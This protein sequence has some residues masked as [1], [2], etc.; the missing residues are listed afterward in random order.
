MAITLPNLRRA[1]ERRASD[2]G[3]GAFIS[4]SGERDRALIPRIQRGV[5]KL[6]KRW[7]QLPPIRIFVDKTSIS[8]GPKLWSKIE[9]GLSRSSW[10]ILLASPEAAASPWVTREVE[11]WLENRRADTILIVLTDGTLRWNDHANDFDADS[12]ALPPP[13]HGQFSEEPVWVAVSWSEGH[14]PNRT[15]IP[16]VERATLDIASVVRGVPKYQLAS[17]AIREHKRTMRWARGAVTALSLLLV[18]ALVFGVLT[19]IQKNRADTEF[20]GAVAARLA[21][22]SRSLLTGNRPPDD[23]RAIGEALASQDLSPETDPGVLLSALTFTPSIR[24]IIVT[25][26][27]M[28]AG[29]DVAPDK[30]DLRKLNPVN[31][32]AFSPDGSRLATAGAQVR[33]WDTETG[34]RTALFDTLLLDTSVVFR[35]DGKRLVTAGSELQRWDDTGA[36]IGPPL[37]G[38]DGF[39]HSVAFSPDGHRLATAGADGTV[40]VWD[41]DGANEIGPPMVGHDGAVKG[42]AFSHDGQRIVSGGADGT[43][44]VW[45]ANSQLPVG[46]PVEIGDDVYAVA[47]HPDDRRVA[48]GGN[49]G[50]RIF[51]PT[52]GSPGDALDGGGMVMLT[53]LTLAF[54][55][56]GHRVIASGMDPAI[57][58]WNVDTRTAIGSATGHTAAVTSV[59]FSPDGNRIASSSHDGTVRIWNSDN[60]RSGGH[61]VTVPGSVDGAPFAKAVALAPDSSRLV[62][63]FTDG[64]LQIVDTDS[65]RPLKP[66]MRGHRGAIDFAAFGPDGHR[67]ASAGVDRTVRIWNADTG[68]AIG[69]P[70]PEHTANIVQLVFSPDG[71]RVLSTSDDNTIRVWDADSGRP[72]G[73]ALLG[74]EV[75]FGNVAFSPDGRVIAAGGAGNTVR[76]WDAATGTP[77]G[78]PLTGHQDV[79]NN[80]AFSP[81]GRRVISTSNDSLRVWDAQTR[82]LVG[83]PH[84]GTNVFGSMAMSPDGSFFV[85]GGTNSMQR[86]NV[87]TGE[88]IGEPIAVHNGIIGDIAV[89]PDSRFIVTGSMDTTMRFWD[90]ANERPFGDPLD[91][92][93]DS[94][95]SVVVS[96]DNWRI[97]TLNISPDDS[98]SAWVWPGPAAWH[99]D[100]CDKLTYDMN[101]TQ[102]SDWVSPNIGYRTL[103]DGLDEFPDE[104]GN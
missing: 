2:L 79:V 53:V 4:Y 45:D 24:K 74:H 48:S 57:R 31:G 83:K 55:P 11:W 14:G 68:E 96:A 63:G 95:A 61:Q 62:A 103:C 12:T 10:L 70:R 87:D 27:P 91:A 40:R 69:Q 9:Y 65:G 34:K 30:I 7:Y 85:T 90:V 77:I 38:H 42:V 72:V 92:G 35:P 99:D 73:T 49:G 88:P 22:H 21:E 60:H 16:D 52:T 102:W 75:Y 93:E 32:V 100:L 81:D 28:Y 64:T 37:Q 51:D 101:R 13:L 59:A 104:S 26:Q 84:L 82:Q 98:V 66:P 39:I 76:L 1:F 29:M 94:V 43:V 23:I 56:D 89:T 36:A 8:A 20:R 71:R 50:V 44:R 15:R 6:A 67:I 25:G 97:L 41:A 18:A 86:R 3:Y 80:V 78:E 33:L 58:M 17:E 5:E 19:L 54:S 47:F 46:Q